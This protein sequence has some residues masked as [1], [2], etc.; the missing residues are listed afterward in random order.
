[1]RGRFATCARTTSRTN[2][3]SMTSRRRRWRTSPL[4]R[5]WECKRN[6]LFVEETRAFDLIE[7]I[8]AVV[9]VVLVVEGRVELTGLEMSSSRLHN[10]FHPGIVIL[11][12]CVICH[13]KQT[14]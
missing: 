6:E 5:S 9:L 13:V 4:W 3:I 14:G 10:A 1:M 11:R 12:V 2:G 8:G 7:E